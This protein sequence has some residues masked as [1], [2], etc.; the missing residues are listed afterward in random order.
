MIE[1]TTGCVYLPLYYVDGELNLSDLLTK[2]HDLTVEDLSTG[3][4]RKV[5]LLFFMDDDLRKSQFSRSWEVHGSQAVHELQYKPGLAE[6][7]L[8]PFPF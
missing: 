3:S 1:W 6:I 4:N 2:K 5:W 7:F 8:F